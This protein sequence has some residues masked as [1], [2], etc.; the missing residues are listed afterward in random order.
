MIDSQQIIV[1]SP[2]WERQKLSIKA[3]RAAVL[4]CHSLSMSWNIEDSFF[5]IFKFCL[6]IAA[7]GVEEN[8]G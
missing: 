1:K 2:S 4:S 6:L 3:L 8:L 7:D 5:A